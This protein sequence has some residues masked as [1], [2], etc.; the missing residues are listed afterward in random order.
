M[1]EEYS[2]TE[3]VLKLVVGIGGSLYGITVGMNAAAVWFIDR[4]V[5]LKVAVEREKRL[6]F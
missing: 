3:K 5:D 2:G 4:R 1:A 6:D